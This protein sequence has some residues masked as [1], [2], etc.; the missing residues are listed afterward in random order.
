VGDSWKIKI[1]NETAFKWID[2]FGSAGMNAQSQTGYGKVE[3]WDNSWLSGNRNYIWDNIRINDMGDNDG[4]R[5]FTWHW[6]GHGAYH[7]WSAGHNI[8]QSGG[9]LNGNEGHA[10]Q[11]VQLWAR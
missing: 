1:T 5:L 3:R 11:F 10:L 4:R 6:D 9:F 7:G 2:Q 8:G